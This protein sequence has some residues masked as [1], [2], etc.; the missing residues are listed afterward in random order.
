MRMD[1]MF[2]WRVR[3]K[4]LQE[5]RKLINARGKR[6]EVYWNTQYYPKTIYIISTIGCVHIYRILEY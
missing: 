6:T 2:N 3:T 1:F 4:Q 5:K